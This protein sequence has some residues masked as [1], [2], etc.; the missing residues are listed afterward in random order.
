MNAESCRNPGYTCRNAPGNRHGTALIRF[1]LEPL[2]RPRL[3][4]LVHLGRIDPRIDR[5][6]H[7]RHAARHRRIAGLRHHRRRGQ[8]RHRRLAHRD[9]VAARPHHPHESHDVVNEL[10]EPEAALRQW[11]VPRVLPVGDVDVVLRQHHLHRAAQQRREMARH[12]RHQQHPRLHHRAFLAEMQQRAERRVVGCFL[13]DADMPVAHRHR[14]DPELRA[15]MRQPGIGKQRQ[16][17]R[18]VPQRR[19]RA[20]PEVRTVRPAARPSWRTGASGSSISACA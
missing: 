14:G 6:R 5:P 3:R 2:D 8:R 18:Q 19:R 11:N 7:Q 12:R 15:Q 10:I 16:A 17:G 4:Q 9:D 20:R 13:D 1:L